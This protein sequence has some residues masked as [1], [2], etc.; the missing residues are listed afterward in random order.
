M[1]AKHMHKKKKKRKNKKQF[2][3]PTLLIL[4]LLAV[5][6]FS[7]WQLAGIGLEY[8]QG[9][10]IYQ[11]LENAVL[12]SSVA[13]VDSVS[14]GSDSAD[15][16]YTG[17]QNSFEDFPSNAF[18]K[19]DFPSLLEQNPD[20]VGWIFLEDTRISYPIVQAE[21]NEW[22]MTHLFD[23]T[24]NKSGSIFLDYR[25]LDDFSDR[26]SII[27]GHRMKNGTM[28][29]GLRYFDSQDYYDAHPLFLLMTPDQ[30]YVVEIFS[31]YIASV[32]DDSWK[33]SFENEDEY[34][35]WLKWLE[36][37]SCIDADFTPT[38]QDRIVT[39]S[40]CTGTSYDVRLVVHGRILE[41]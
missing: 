39:F 36:Q 16:D 17:Y 23:G 14:A 8:Y 6:L 27:Y 5:F 1:E 31:A 29:A 40:T 9:K 13:S 19:V 41:Q 35:D 22:Y 20:T 2:N 28:F 38:I 21:D 10:K 4:L 11:N 32:N 30:N 33:L 34:A 18:L 26:H 25:N 24:V 7:A 3:S 15:R 12:E 37:S